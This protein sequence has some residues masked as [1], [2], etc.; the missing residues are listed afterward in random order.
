MA[1]KSKSSKKK[2]S[3]SVSKSSSQSSTAAPEKGKAPASPPATDPANYFVPAVMGLLA[4]GAIGMWA[5]STTAP[6][7][8]AAM[9]G[10]S[11]RGSAAT[12]RRAA[13]GMRT[14]RVL[15][16]PEQVPANAA[17]PMPATHPTPTTPDPRGG[18]FSLQQATEGM[19]PG[20]GLYAEIETNYGTFNCEL[21]PD[22]AP[23]TVANFVGLA[24]GK[25]EFW[26]PQQ[27]QW[28]TRAYFD[29]TVFHRVIP[30][31]MVQ[32]GDILRSGHGGPG[33]EIADE[34]VTA[35]NEGG[36][37]CMANHGPNTGGSQFFVLEAG[38]P[39]LDGS[40]SVFGKCDPVALVTAIA[41][42]PRGASD[43][44]NSPV[45][46]RHVRISR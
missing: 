40:Y 9:T 16:Q 37:L 20:D 42:A 27:G 38:K 33:Y 28:A 30:G 34:N 32:G 2:K 24:R 15:P 14:G 29:G 12:I 18:H 35:H 7:E 39:H 10:S 31:F 22:R 21:W 45:L 23:N 26:D 36:L 41:A 43:R 6:P 13:G 44:P 19:P 1:D 25:R 3:D 5:K 8:P 46:I 11:D 4:V 17:D